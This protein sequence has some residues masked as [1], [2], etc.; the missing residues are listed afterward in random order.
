MDFVRLMTE[1]VAN[2]WMKLR[3][4]PNRTVVNWRLGW[5]AGEKFLL[6]RTKTPPTAF[7]TPASLTIVVDCQFWIHYGPFAPPQTAGFSINNIWTTG[8]ILLKLP[9]LCKNRLWSKTEFFFF[10][11]SVR[12]MTLQFVRRKLYHYFYSV[13]YLVFYNYSFFN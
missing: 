8:G 7:T 2:L 13:L 6:V 10:E 12:Q 9:Q 1:T 5:K 3:Y 11:S 4:L